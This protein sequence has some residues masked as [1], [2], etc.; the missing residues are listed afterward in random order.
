M[1]TEIPN[2][3]QHPGERRRRWFSSQDQDL[4]IWQ[5]AAGEIRAF[6]LCYSKHRNEHAIYW[7]DD[8]GFAHLTV[9]DGEA[10][11][12]SS[13][14]P[15]LRMNGHFD[16]SKVIDAFSR[17]AGGLPAPIGEFILERLKQYPPRKTTG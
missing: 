12:L 8:R 13:A 2:T 10:S 3:R 11:P 6:Q 15:T 9:D 7:R 4:Y 14:T 1:L 17:Q 5:D 16:A